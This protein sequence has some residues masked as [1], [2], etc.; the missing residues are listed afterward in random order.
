MQQPAIISIIALSAALAGRS[1][2][3]RPAYPVKRIPLYRA[4][5][6]GGADAMAR[7]LAV[8]HLSE[9]LGQQVVIEIAAARAPHHRRGA[10]R[11]GAGR[12][13][14]RCDGSTNLAAAPS[15][16]G[17]TGLRHAEGFRSGH[18]AGQNAQHFCG[19]SIAAG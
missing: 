12:T 18:A 8:P 19:A 7:L 1:T 10:R 9:R 4:F 5:K 14:T 11:Q 16:H 17:Q 3:R 13:V 6:R 2:T 15:L